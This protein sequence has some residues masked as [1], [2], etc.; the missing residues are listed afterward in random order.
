MS[1][2]IVDISILLVSVLLAVYYTKS[3]RSSEL[4]VT[5]TLWLLI[6]VAIVLLPV[7]FAA[8]STLQVLFFIAIS[9]VLLKTS[10]YQ[11]KI[12][13]T[14]NWVVDKFRHGELILKSL[15]ATLVVLAASWLFIGALFTIPINTTQQLSQSSYILNNLSNTLNYPQ[16]E[17]AHLDQ[18]QVSDTDIPEQA[19][20]V[21]KIES[22]GC[23]GRQYG[24]GFVI[25]ADIVMT[26]AHVVAG[27]KQPTIRTS[28]NDT[29]TAQVVYFDPVEDIALLKVKDL[30]L[31]SLAI[32]EANHPHA[33]SNAVVIGYPAGR[34]MRLSTVGVIR[35]LSFYDHDIYNL[36]LK[37]LDRYEMQVEV[38]P[39]SS[40]SPV[41]TADGLV[42]GMISAT[43]DIYYDVGYAVTATSLQEA[44][45]LYESQTSHNQAVVSSR[46]P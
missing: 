2:S 12:V 19:Q 9:L 30:G 22:I 39:G 1:V 13:A 17:A 14:T 8:N 4:M 41:V 5:A 36:S 45:R 3:R 31:P 33:E 27:I 34:D 40:G 29:A 42:T 23:G 16:V 7:V 24:S 11:D 10:D 46:C 21:V 6:L 20:S 38:A 44:M 28:S 35:P 25:D 37:E 26:N 32:T 43:S 15:S 18:Q